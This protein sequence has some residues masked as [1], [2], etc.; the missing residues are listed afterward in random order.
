[1][2]EA[3]GSAILSAIGTSAAVAT[4]VRI[5]GVS[6]ATIVGTATVLGGTLL[7]QSLITPDIKQ[8]V[9]SQQFSSRQSL[10]PRRRAYGTVML[11]GPKIE[12]RS[13]NGRFYNEIYHVEGP[14]DAFLG[15]WLEDK[16]ATPL[17][18]Q[19]TG[20]AG[21]A[22]WNGSVV[23]EAHRG[24]PDQAASGLLMQLPQW[25]ADD[26]LRGCAAAPTA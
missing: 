26:R 23:V 4:T 12:Y 16:R 2:V 14:I 1:M 21:I 15:F 3:I 22:P 11:A 19:L 13:L 20:P 7:L 5:A 9:A 6:L 24:Y 18:N 17:D 10:P 25:S 8:K